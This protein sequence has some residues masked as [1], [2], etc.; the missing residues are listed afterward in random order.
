MK[1]LKKY[2]HNRFRNLKLQLKQYEKKTDPEALHRIR[3]ELKKI[4]VLFHLLDF[5]SNNFNAK[6]E[7]KPLKNIFRK[8]GRIRMFDVVAQVLCVHKVDSVRQDDIPDI[9]KKKKYVSSF[10]ETTPDFQHIIRKYDRRVKKYLEQVRAGCLEKYLVSKKNEV[11]KNLLR[12]LPLCKLHEARKLIKEVVYLSPLLKDNSGDT[13]YYQSL[14]STIGRW[15]DKKMLLRLLRKNKKGLNSKRIKKLET[16]SEND[17][18]K[19]KLF[20]SKK[21]KIIYNE[22]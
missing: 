5:C 17:L 15:H 13:K 3:V 10:K 11:R 2:A 21:Y 22:K 4:K 7:Y 1:S 6:W 14:Q 8:A 20:I 18:K 16:E 9:K 19:L 12:R